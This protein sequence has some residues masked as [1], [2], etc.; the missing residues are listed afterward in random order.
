VLALRDGRPVQKL[1]GPEQPSF[2]YDDGFRS[3]LAIPIISRHA[4]G[5]VLLVHRTEPRLFNQNEI[6]LLL[7]FANY[8]TLAWEHAVLYERSD[9]RLREVA[10]ENE[11]LY[12]QASEEKQ[13]LEAIMGSMSDGLVLTGIDGKVLYANLGA[14]AIVGLPSETLERHSISALYDALRTAAIDPAECER[15][16]AQAES[17]EATQGVVEI[18][19]N[20]RRHAIHLRLFDV[21]DESGRAIGRGLLLRDV[22][23]EREL[24]EF[25]TALLAAVGHELRTP[26]AAI[27]GHASTLLQEDVTWPLADQRHS[28]QT[29]SGEADRLAQL[30]SNLLDLSRQ[31]AGL[32]LLNCAPASMQDLV[33]KAIERL[34]HP[35][36][37]I[38]LQ[39][40]GDLPLVNVDSGRIEVVLHN[41]ITNAL[42]YGEGEVRIAAGRRDDVIV[43]SVSDNG[44]GIASDELPHVFERFYRARHGRQQH[45]G[46]TGLGLTICKAFVEAHGGTIWA[47]SSLLGTTISFSL[48]LVSPTVAA[49][50]VD[51][52][53]TELS[54]GERRSV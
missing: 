8:A 23:R 30:V 37:T 47:E 28:L 7:T 9:E 50:P 27:K 54:T 4:G 53:A 39:I 38:S 19:R 42:M 31:E 33:A 52:A 51:T 45:S 21:C 46:G 29:I 24:D 5:V 1:L 14:S 35:E 43:V 15:I 41:L 34:N 48:P 36:A 13:K 49:V 44:P 32:L 3:V 25:K 12:Q 20:G 22:T 18:R 6:D 11:R 16:L 2:S 10:R 40:P 17:A 26:L